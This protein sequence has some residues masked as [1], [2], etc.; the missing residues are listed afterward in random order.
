MSENLEEKIDER[1]HGIKWQT[2]EEWQRYGLEHGYD[3]R[4]PSSLVKSENKEERSWISKGKREGWYK[5]FKFERKHGIKWQTKEEWQRYGLEHGYDKRN[6]SSLVKSENKEERSWI[7]KG[8]QEGWYKE[9]KFER[10]RERN[11]DAHL[12][13]ILKIYV[14]K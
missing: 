10:K 8:M 6:L 5:E 9:F 13:E 7:N 2:K 12:I 4:N 3:K 14:K 11:K 1:K